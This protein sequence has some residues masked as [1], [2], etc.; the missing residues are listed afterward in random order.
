MANAYFGDHPGRLEIPGECL[1][2]PCL[3]R[4][5]R[6]SR[7]TI[8]P[9]SNTQE[10][11]V[12]VTSQSTDAAVSASTESAPCL[13]C[14][15]TRAFDEVG[16]RVCFCDSCQDRGCLPGKEI[17]CGGCIVCGCSSPFA[18]NGERICGCDSCGRGGCVAQTPVGCVVCGCSREQDRSGDR[19][20]FCDPCQNDGCRYSGHVYNVLERL[21]TVYR[22]DFV[23]GGN[24]DAACYESFSDDSHH[25]LH[26]GCVVC[27]CSR[28]QDRS[29]DRI[30]FCD[31][32]QND[33]CRYSGRVYNVLGRLPTVYRYDFVDGG[34]DDAARYGSF[35]DDLHHE[36]HHGPPGSSIR[37]NQ[38]QDRLLALQYRDISP[39]DYAL[40]LVLH[41]ENTQRKTIEA[42]SLPLV[43]VEEVLIS[44]PL[45]SNGDTDVCAICIEEFALGETIRRLEC[46]HV[47]HKECID[48]W[49]TAGAAEC[50]IDRSCLYDESA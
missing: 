45:D 41:E 5:P 8:V 46:S 49:L 3:T 42:N 15:C 25:E 44:L 43:G 7:D 29:G 2:N 27:G 50:P 24:D 21:P 19:I 22:Y 17:D 6:L 35:S 33:G 48:K 1:K 20:C 10:C 34:N 30:C 18:D 28:E 12:T 32:C 39:D 37:Q 4:T 36:W 11:G 16:D 38:V 47:F 40:L 31:P 26:Q 9:E 13:A 23:D 14:G